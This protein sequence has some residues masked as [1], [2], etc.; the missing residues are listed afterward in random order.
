MASTAREAT[1]KTGP[2][3]AT[4]RVPLRTSTTRLTFLFTDIE[5]S[6]PT[7]ERRPGEMPVSLARH[8]ELLHQAVAAAGGRVFQHTGDGICAAFSTAPAAL[9]AALAA[10][11]A[12]QGAKWKEIAPLRVRHLQA[13]HRLSVGE[14]T[15]N[16]CVRCRHRRPSPGSEGRTLTEL[17]QALLE[18]WRVGIAQPS[19]TFASTFWPHQLR[20]IAAED[21]ARRR[22][23]AVLRTMM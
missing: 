8:D 2:A 6:T 12:V 7:W 19:R 13:G 4:E 18:V 15:M 22:L 23:D 10:Q 21:A 5:A 9:A 3:K 17:G 1:R 16:T 20:R 11:R 14:R